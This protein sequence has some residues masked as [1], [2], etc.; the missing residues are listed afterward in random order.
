MGNASVTSAAHEKVEIMADN[1]PKEKM[2]AE[3]LR[4]RGNELHDGRRFQEAVEVYSKA[5]MKD[6]S[7]PTFYTNRAL[8]YLR[9]QRW[10]LVCKDCSTAIERDP[11]CLK[12][13]YFMGV[14]FTE[15]GNHDEAI[16]LL[17]KANDLAMKQRQS[18]GDEIT[19]MIRLC[20]KRRWNRQ[21]EKR[22]SQEIDL[23]VYLHRLIEEEKQRQLGQL[24]SEWD[25]GDVASSSASSSADASVE[26]KAAE[27]ERY[28][29]EKKSELDRLLSEV[30]DRR[31]R[32][33]VPDYLCGKISFELMR[34]PVITPSGITYDRR[35]I[36]EHLRRVGHFDP[37]TRMELTQDL[38]IP[39]LAMKEVVDLFLSKNEWAVDY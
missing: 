20:R 26:K 24:R 14:A 29:Q 31:K 3:Q 33:D 36:D 2:T 37:V 34:D 8:C 19:S 6:P 32:R 27:L 9:L 7:V 25:D 13:Y 11:N 28:H 23:Q 35:D 39:N 38:L 22:I 1:S 18:Y 16:N 5:I 15:K 4:K 30:D 12:A 17:Q 21:E 10:D